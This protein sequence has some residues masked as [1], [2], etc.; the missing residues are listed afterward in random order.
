MQ[1]GGGGGGGGGESVMK[2]YLLNNLQGAVPCITWDISW[3][4]SSAEQACLSLTW[5]KNE[6]KVTLAIFHTKFQGA[7]KVQCTHWA[8]NMGHIENLVPRLYKKI[9]THIK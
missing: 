3:Q 2:F 7:V 5:S 9:H 4:F 8:G 6:N 1:G